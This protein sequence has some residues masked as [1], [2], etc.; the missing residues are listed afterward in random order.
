MLGKWGGNRGL[1]Y[2]TA[3]TSTYCVHVCESVY[4]QDNSKTCG[5]WTDSD[6]IL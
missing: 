6:E 5:V 1:E 3:F 2:G 4:E